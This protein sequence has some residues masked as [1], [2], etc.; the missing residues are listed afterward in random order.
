MDIVKLF[1]AAAVLALVINSGKPYHI[2]LNFY[3][4][5]ITMNMK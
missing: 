2:H 4:N 3:P 1:V 5:E